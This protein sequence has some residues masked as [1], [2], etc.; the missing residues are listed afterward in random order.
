MGFLHPF[1][2]PERR[3]MRRIKKRGC[4][5]WKVMVPLLLCVCCM[6]QAAESSAVTIERG[7]RIEYPHYWGINGTHVYTAHTQDGDRLAYCMQPDKNPIPTGDYTAQITEGNEGLRAALYYGYGG[8]GQSEY[9]DQAEY[10]YLGDCTVEDAKYV[11]THLAVSY[12]YDPDHAFHNMDAGDVV[13]SGVWDF[14]EWLKGREIPQTESS[15]SASEL[16]AYYEE[17]TDY[18]RTESMQYLSNKGDN[19]ITIHCPEGVK[20]H[21]ESTGIEETGQAVVKA[22]ESFYFKAPLD[23]VSKMGGFW[24][25]GDMKGEKDG[26]WEAVSVPATGDFQV[27]GYGYYSQLHTQSIG[28][29][30]NWISMGSLEVQKKDRETGEKKPQGKGSFEGAVYTV[31]KGAQEIGTIVTDKNGYGKLEHVPT[32]TYTVKETKAPLGY[33]LDATVHTVTVKPQTTGSAVSVTSEE[34]AIRVKLNVQ[35]LDH[36]TGKNVPQGKGSLKGARYSVYAGEAIGTLKK[37]EEAGQ[38]ITDENG[39]GSLDHLLPG[40]YYVKETKASEGYFLDPSRYEVTFPLDGSRLEDTITSREKPVKGQIEIRKTEEET[41]ENKAQVTGTSFEGTVY[42][43]YAEETIGGLQKGDKVTEIKINKEGYGKAENLLYGKYK[44]KELSAPAGYLLDTKEYQ[45]VIPQ[46]QEG[47]TQL[48]VF[49]NSREKPVR[50]DVAITKFLKGQESEAFR[51]PGEGISFIITEKGNEKNSIKIT[52]DKNGF[53]STKDAAY[54]NGRLLYGTYEVKEDNVPFGYTGIAPFEVTVQENGQVLYYIIENQEILCPV[55]ITKTA[56][57]TGQVIAVAGTKFKIQ[58]KERESWKDQEFLVTVY[59][60]EVRQTIF[61]TDETGSFHLPEKLKAGDYR[62]VEIQPP[63]GYALNETPLEFSVQNGMEIKERLEIQYEDDPQQGKIR[64]QKKDKET[65]EAAGSG[66]VF[67]I[68]AGEDIYTKDGTLRLQKGQEADRITTDEKGTADSKDLYPGKYLVKEEL[69]GEHY[70]IEKEPWEVEVK[71]EK[72][73]KNFQVLCTIDNKKTKVIIEKTDAEAEEIPVS[74]TEFR[75]YRENQLTK[76]QIENLGS[77]P[78]LGGELMVTDSSGFCSVQNLLHNTRYYLVETK[79]AEGY[80]RDTRVYEFFVDEKG[81]IDGK[82]E[83]ALKV[84]N[85]PVTVEIQKVSEDGKTKV[86]GAELVLFNQENQEITRWTSGKKPYRIQRLKAGTYILKEE[87]APKG[88][89]AAENM[90]FTVKAVKEIQK[91]EMTD[92]FLKGRITIEKTDADKNIALGKGFQFEITAAED[93]LSPEKEKVWKKGDRIETIS[94]DE[95]GKAISSRLFPG[96]YQIQESVSGEYYAAD[97]TIYTGEILLT[98]DNQV[99]DCVIKIPNT[100]T[101]LILE[102]QDAKKNI[103][104]ENVVF[105]VSTSADWKEGEKLSREAVE[106]YGV[107]ITTDKQGKAQLGNLKHNCTYYVTEKKTLKGYV[108]DES[109]YSFQVDEKGLI[110]KEKEYL[111]KLSNTPNQVEIY[112]KDGTNKELL[113]GAVLRL[114]DQEGAEVETWETKKEPYRIT[115]LEAGEYILQEVR[116]PEGYERA[117]DI[118]LVLRDSLEVQ[119]VVMYDYPE[120][121]RKDTEQSNKEQKNIEK[122]GE[123]VKTGDEKLIGEFLLLFMFS[124]GCLLVLAR[125]QKKQ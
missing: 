91:I 10:K 8:P 120:K 69:A 34:K 87:N 29:L 74:G 86:S 28:F 42:G 32:G 20:L 107:E 102:K 16:T 75:L 53:A 13:N 60:K 11:L 104:M 12:F 31:Y 73:E 124:G 67:S 40:K 15:F 54:P 99:K 5:I 4:W 46:A 78:I 79:A 17:G 63:K 84:K 110:N 36:E 117:E 108:L 6:V 81:L 71:P 14:I 66:F 56:A 24:E 119:Y 68:T 103:P 18:Q 106:E 23:I 70:A 80:V 52:T 62:I 93:I 7:R 122:K 98:K 19:Q 59:P 35:K 25:S 64:I 39:K 49:I 116:A 37:D 55:R 112:K 2:F 111:L 83:L 72:Y 118:K 61:E 82:E 113:E 77:N 44:V 22:N 125:K 57:D 41:G 65:K 97:E 95:N 33:E 101:K 51:K 114:I 121:A 30:V 90:Q 94:T 100:K 105:A 109:I 89:Q 45:A 21:H 96:K 38:I 50:G 58:K 123:A 1:S 92:A 76:E 3:K 48:K 9:I 47:S 85:E 43:I 88:Y 115:G 26:R 27:S